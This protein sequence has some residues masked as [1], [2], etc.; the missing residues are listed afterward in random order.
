MEHAGFSREQAEVSVKILIEVMNEN[1]ATKA[2]V[3]E[4]VTRLG[5]R[6]DKLEST[7]QSS[8]KELDY[9]LTIKLGAMITIAMGS[10]VTLM[11]LLET[12]QR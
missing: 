12:I 1:F 8:I 6:I 4:M 11:R 9:R 10:T 5:S 7:V 3:N 2:D